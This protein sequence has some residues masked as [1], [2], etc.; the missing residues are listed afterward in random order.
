MHR[1][2]V[3]YELRSHCLEVTWNMVILDLNTPHLDDDE[4]HYLPECWKGS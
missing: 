4:D 1:G 2:L 3:L